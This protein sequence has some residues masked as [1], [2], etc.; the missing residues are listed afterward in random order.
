MNVSVFDVTTVSV[1]A[2]EAA[3]QWLFLGLFS[4]VFAGL[5]SLLLV[6]SRTP[7]VKEQIPGVDFFHIALVVHVDLS[8]LIWFLSFSAC[9]WRLSTV[10]LDPMVH[11]I[12]YILCLSGTGLVVLS[13]FL[14]ADRPILNNYVPVLSHPLFLFGLMLFGLGILI[15]ATDQ[16]RQGLMRGI[17]V[18][19]NSPAHLASWLSASVVLISVLAVFHAWISIPGAL[20]ETFFYEVLFWGGGHILQFSHSLLMLTAW[21]W[22]LWACYA[23]IVVR[24]RT[25]VLFMLIA[26]TPIASLPWVYAQG[27]LDGGESRFAFTQLMKWGGMA[28]L[29]LGLSLGVS[30]FFLKR[31][32]LNERPYQNALIASLILFLS[33]GIIGFMIEGVNVVIP[34]HYHGSIVGVTLSFM[35]MAYFLLPRLGLGPVNSVWA[36]RQPFIYG[37]GQLLHII[38]LAWS[39]GYGVQRK[40]AGAAQT[41][42]RL[43]EILG[44]GMMGLGGLISIV[45]GIAFLLIA[46][47][48]W[49]RR[50]P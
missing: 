44:M 29:P 35:G 15:E 42:D 19:F 36:A 5:F 46:Y 13:P 34:A 21:I 39:G 38:G 50:V 33:G 4:L 11:R 47:G 16:F 18:L 8:V 10:Q 48:S 6:L 32:Q 30:L 24:N 28:T 40:T 17:G 1:S 3:R 26:V 43:P 41:L 37:G 31:P 12:A 2:K 14:G 49:K 27:P 20:Q 22:L 25:I 7:F 23:R 45:G 9:L